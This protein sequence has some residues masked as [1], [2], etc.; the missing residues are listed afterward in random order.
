MV[1]LETTEREQVFVK[2]VLTCDDETVVVAQNVIWQNPFTHLTI[3]AL[4]LLQYT[5]RVPTYTLHSLS[6]TSVVN[7]CKVSSPAHTVTIPVW[8]LASCGRLIEAIIR[9]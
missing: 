2:R 6:L 1:A 7:H 9:I 5:T 8:G 3:P 4:T